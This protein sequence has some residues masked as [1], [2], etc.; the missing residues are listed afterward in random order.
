M[1]RDQSEK[2]TRFVIEFELLDHE[3]GY[4]RK[5]RREGSSW[6]EIL[7]CRQQAYKEKAKRN[8]AKAYR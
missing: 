7:K 4:E 3:T 8:D 6:K 1:L 5:Q 2:F